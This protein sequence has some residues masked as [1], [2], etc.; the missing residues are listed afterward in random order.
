MLVTSTVYSGKQI[1]CNT[2]QMS[3]T[4][5]KRGYETRIHDRKTH[6]TESNSKN[7]QYPQR[8]LCS[9]DIEYN[10]Y[11]YNQA[12]CPLSLHLGYFAQTFITFSRALCFDTATS[13]PLTPDYWPVISHIV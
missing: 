5:T 2:R 3:H 10:P 9:K 8:D 7:Y 4:S 11:L 13:H 1:L 6:T 12:I